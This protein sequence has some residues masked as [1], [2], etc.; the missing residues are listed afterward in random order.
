MMLRGVSVC[1]HLE[2]LSLDWLAVKSWFGASL[3]LCCSAP[4]RAISPHAFNLG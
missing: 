2:H 1:V 3:L 4:A